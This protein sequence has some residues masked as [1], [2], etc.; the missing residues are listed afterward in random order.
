VSPRGQ[1]EIWSTPPAPRP[2]APDALAGP[3]V[4][5]LTGDWSDAMAEARAMH[6]A[7]QPPEPSGPR[8]ARRRL[9]FLAAVV[10]AIG[11][12]LIALGTRLVAAGD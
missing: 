6:E 4:E 11:T 9:A 3:R 12:V 1:D 7:M 2:Y 10:R 5:G 8:H